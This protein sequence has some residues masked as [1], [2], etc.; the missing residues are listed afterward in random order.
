[1]ELADAGMKRELRLRRLEQGETGRLTSFY[2]ENGYD[3]PI[4]DEEIL[5]VVE[6]E[7]RILA[8]LRLCRENG[9]SVLRGMIVREL[10]RGL[11]LGTLLLEYA[12]SVL[13]G[14]N[15]YCVPY[16]ELERFYSRIGFRR[17]D[18]A[19][20][21]EFLRERQR[22]Y[23]EELGLDVILMYRQGKGGGS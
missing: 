3:S 21:P 7:D 10:H 9:E 15:C 14:E 16:R 18:P 20:A 8:A 11:G 12:E 19:G 5:L 22:V 2:L 1:M 6:A 17:I 4:E 23:R 13:A